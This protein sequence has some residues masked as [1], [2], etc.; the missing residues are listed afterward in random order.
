MLK[1]MMCLQVE[2]PNS[3]TGVVEILNSSCRIGGH[4]E[5]SGHTDK[6]GYHIMKLIYDDGI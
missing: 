1:N 6:N 3:L 4:H 5:C 2:P